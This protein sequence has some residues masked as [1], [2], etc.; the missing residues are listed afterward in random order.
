M[1]TGRR[2]GSFNGRGNGMTLN[3]IAGISQAIS[4][5]AVVASLFF[6][7]IQL[8]R[9]TR[10]SRAVSHHAITEA[11]NHVN[12]VWARD[13]ELSL[14]WLT[15]LHDRQGLAPDERWRFDAML[16]AYFL[17]CETMHTQANLGIGD[18]DIVRAEK[19]GIR[20]VLSHPGVQ[21]WWKHNPFGFSNAFRAYVD[22]IH[23]THEYG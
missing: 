9:N 1:Q 23:E 19:D 3:Q 4:S 5:A 15:G 18:A 11:L 20:F 6:V 13:R 16:R 10:A 17:V 2:L 22:R 8:R 7:G 21:D 14:I 12:L